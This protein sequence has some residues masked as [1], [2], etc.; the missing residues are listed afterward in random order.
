MLKVK[1]MRREIR[2]ERLEDRRLLSAAL[3]VSNTLGFSNTLMAFNAVENSTASQT[4]TLILTDSGDATLSLNSISIANDPA[5]PTQDA[6]RFTILNSAS[7]PSALS[8]GQSFGLQLSYKAIAHVIN[9]AFLNI[10]TNATTQ[11]VALRG[12]GAIGLGGSNQPSLAMILRGY[13]IPTIVGEG[14]NDSD[15]LTDGTYPNPPD[16]SSQEV[17][18]QTLVKAGPGSVTIQTLASFTASG[19]KPYTLG[20]YTPG[21]PNTADLHE[22]FFTPTSESQSVYVQPDG[23]TSF[24]PGNSQFGFYFVSNVQVK[25]RIGYSEDALN[26]WDTTNDRKFRFFPMETSNGTVVPNTYVMTTTEFNAP[27]GYDFTNIVAVVSNVKAA[28]GAPSGPVL[29]LDNLNAI[30][31]SN[32]MIFNRIQDPNTTIGDMVHDTGV[33]QI[34]NTGSNNLTIS[35]M[36][37]NSSAWKLL[38]A[39]A[40]P[41]TL[42]GGGILDLQIKFVATSEPSHH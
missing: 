40:L 25:G 37:L 26:T 33:L 30:P 39:P 23:A 15:Y 12:I 9:S 17:S 4:E 1:R 16:A 14:A 32:T 8:P 35:S 7:I 18:L 20:M 13:E 24:D 3:S 2:T 27:V 10:A 11:Q 36:T 5:S 34:E 29:G 41:F 19:T 31:G 38:N 42:A 6:A 22:L 21:N 28:P